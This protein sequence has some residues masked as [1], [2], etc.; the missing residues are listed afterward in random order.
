MERALQGKKAIITAGASGIGL[1]VVRAMLEN[2]ASVALCDVDDDKLAALRRAHPG[3]HAFHC[4]VAK[5]A[6]VA[7]FIDQAIAA[8]GGVDILVNNAG[9]AGPTAPVEEVTPAE[10]DLT[11]AV[12]LSAQFYATSLVVPHLKRQRAGS[13][14]NMSSVAGRLGI[15]LRTPYAAAKWGVIG[16]TQSLAMEL[17]PFGVRVNAILPGPVTGERMERVLKDRAERRGVSIEEIRA[18]EVGTISLR[19]MIEPEEIAD[20]IVFVC[21]DKGRSISGQSLSVCGNME[22]LR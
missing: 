13:I 6:E 7:R 1:V 16:F 3:V 4:D 5:H 11:V 15:P 14:V 17:G 10:W 22:T 9:I 8:L 21:S 18:E 2:G 12:C 19:R 20:M